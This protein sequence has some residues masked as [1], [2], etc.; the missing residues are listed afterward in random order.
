M[1]NRRGQWTLLFALAMLPIASF[2]GGCTLWSDYSDGLTCSKDEDC[3]R[4]QG[5][6]CD[7]VIKE[8]VAGLQPRLPAPQLAVPATS[9]TALSM[10]LD[11]SG[12]IA[13]DGSLQAQ[14]V[15]P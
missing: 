6:V 15:Q 11:E 12:E 8:C 4:A 5:E 10:P 1:V 3:F 9:G 13:D 7:L 14:Q 2:A